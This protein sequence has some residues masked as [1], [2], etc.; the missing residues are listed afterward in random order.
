MRKR[1]DKRRKNMDRRQN[2]G[3]NQVNKA[4]LIIFS[5]DFEWICTTKLIKTAK[6][7]E[8]AK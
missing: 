5:Q 3:S 6:K 2:K 4:L 8:K 1:T 7:S